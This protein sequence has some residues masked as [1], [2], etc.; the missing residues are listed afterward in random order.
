LPE[1]CQSDSHAV[2]RCWSPAEAIPRCRWHLLAS[3]GADSGC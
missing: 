2:S 1:I 3:T